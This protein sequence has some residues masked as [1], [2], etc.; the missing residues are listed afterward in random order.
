MCEHGGWIAAKRLFGEGLPVLRGSNDEIPR[1]A[2]NDEYVRATGH[3]AHC[4]Q[5]ET[6]GAHRGLEN[7]GQAGHLSDFGVSDWAFRG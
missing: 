6:I 1:Y 3:D 2:R 7:D 4:D 5:R